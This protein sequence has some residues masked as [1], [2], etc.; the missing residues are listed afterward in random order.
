MLRLST[1]RI[2]HDM[3]AVAVADT[4]AGLAPEGRDRLF[5]PFVTT[6]STGMEIGLSICRRMVESRRQLWAEHN[7]GGGTATL[8]KA[9][10]A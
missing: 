8:Q 7:A 4:G 1:S 10:P 9:A 5:P 3:V 6:K 2:A